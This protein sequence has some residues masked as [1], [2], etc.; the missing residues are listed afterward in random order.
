MLLIH[1]ERGPCHAISNFLRITK[2]QFFNAWRN[3]PCTP[4]PPEP[5]VFTTNKPI[6]VEANATGLATGFRCPRLL[7]H[8][9]YVFSTACPFCL[10]LCLCLG[11]PPS[12]RDFF[13]WVDLVVSALMDKSSS[14]IFG[15]IWVRTGVADA[16]PP[17]PFQ[18]TTY[19]Y[20]GEVPFGGGMLGSNSIGCGLGC[21]IPKTQR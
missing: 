15:W 11:A 13:C 19:G 18:P 10:C 9:F 5:V 3:T 21:G 17:Q 8:S 1:P 7:M 14:E 12:E 4:N 20:S 2:D 16:P 6:D